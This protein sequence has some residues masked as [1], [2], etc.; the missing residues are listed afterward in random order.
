M[1]GL[2]G[3]TQRGMGM[4]P[5]TPKQCAE[6]IGVSLSLIYA[7]LHAGKLVAFRVGVRGKGKWLIDSEDFDAW[8]QSMKVSKAVPVDDGRYKFL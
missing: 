2:E 4:K 8:L 6:R 3:E 1:E 5:L 7:A